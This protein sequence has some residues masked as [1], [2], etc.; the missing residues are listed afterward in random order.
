MM[1]T[2]V[3]PVSPEFVQAWLRCNIG[4]RHVNYQLVAKFAEAMQRGEWILTHQGI[5]FDTAG[6]LIDGQHR[7]LAVI[8]SGRTV[9]MNVTT[10]VERKPGQ[11]LE[12]DTGRGR[13]LANV[14][15][16][17]GI[18]DEMMTKMMPVVRRF[19]K[20]KLGIQYEAHTN[21]FI[22]KFIKS[23]YSALS[24]IAYSYGYIGR[25]NHP[26]AIVGAAAFS[27][28]LAGENPDAVK[29]FGEV[30]STNDVNIANKYRV[31]TALDCKEKVKGREHNADVF[32]YVENCIRCYANNL[33]KVY[34][35][36]CYKLDKY[37][38]LAKAAT[39]GDDK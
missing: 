13:T 9:M 3:I 32:R 21:G 15:L 26:T 33:A 39:L 29:T 11:L 34:I 37:E 12:I 22:I 23:Q 27:A 2:K 16:M 30:W 20:T 10:G 19:L 7:L 25:K 38:L 28:L 5:A 18:T 31:K 17:S 6:V 8:K 36:D 14:L 1:E 35:V 24:E 4:N